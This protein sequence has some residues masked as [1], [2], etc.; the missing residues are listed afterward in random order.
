[1]TN[2]TSIKD[3]RGQAILYQLDK[4]KCEGE[5][6]LEK[7]CRLTLAIHNKDICSILRDNQKM[8]G[9]NTNESTRDI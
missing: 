4:C 9:N 8:E 3:K 5:C 2:S 7:P 6:P 1:M